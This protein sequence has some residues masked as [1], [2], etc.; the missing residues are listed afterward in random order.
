M[1]AQRHFE[2]RFWPGR[3]VVPI[4]AVLLAHGP[5]ARAGT[6]ITTEAVNNF[7]AGCKPDL[8][9]SIANVNGF[10]SRMTSVAGFTLGPGFQNTFVVTSDFTEVSDSFNFDRNNQVDAISYVHTHGGW[11]SPGA[12]CTTGSQC[13][14]PGGGQ[15]LPGVCLRQK[16]SGGTSGICVYKT[17]RTLILGDCS[18]VDYTNNVRWGESAT[19]GGW[20]GAGTDGGVN[21]V[22]IDNSIAIRPSQYIDELDFTHAGVATIGLLMVT[23]VGQT[24]PFNPDDAINVSTRGTAFANRYVAN[25]GSSVAASWADTVNSVSGGASCVFGGGGH[26][27]NGCGAHLSVSAD[28]TA[29]FANFDQNANWTQIRDDN[30]DSFGNSFYQWQFICNYNCNAHPFEL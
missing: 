29:G 21:F 17:P 11:D 23:R 6:G 2:W 28:S 9:N 7:Q 16:E 1:D 15:S 3:L 18:T 8:P 25:Q 13:N 30:N 12:V 20:A 27:F 24:S 10:R 5:A 22:V 4:A 19:A 14:S 26:G